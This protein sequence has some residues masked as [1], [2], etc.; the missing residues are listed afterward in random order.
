MRRKVS[1]MFFTLS[2]LFA[3]LSMPF[4]GALSSGKLERNAIA[5]IAGDDEGILKL[6]GFHNNYY[7]MNNKYTEFGTITNNTMEKMNLTVAVTPQ[8]NLLNAGSTFKI[9]LGTKEMI[10]HFGAT[11][12]KQ[13]SISLDPKETVNVSA[14]LV[15]NITGIYSSFQFTATNT[16]GTY[17]MV[18][19]NSKDIPRGVICY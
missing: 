19:Q 16:D 9:K 14:F 13:I 2:I 17:S 5:R 1:V 18:L 12:T 15:N 4:G 6:N 7:N 10:F 11:P 3:I 8:F